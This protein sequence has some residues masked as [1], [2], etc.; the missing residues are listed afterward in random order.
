MAGR[1]SAP[2]LADEGA[3]DAP[4]RDGSEAQLDG[5]GIQGKGATEQGL[6]ADP[7]RQTNNQAT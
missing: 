2:G 5:N 7:A 4:H 6:A 1:S 3:V